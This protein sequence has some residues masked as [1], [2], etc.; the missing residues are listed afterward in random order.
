MIPFPFSKE[1]DG[2]LSSFSNLNRA[3]ISNT[4]NNNEAYNIYKA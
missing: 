2:S 4:I 3:H 1:S